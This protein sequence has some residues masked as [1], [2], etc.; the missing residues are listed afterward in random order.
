MQHLGNHY[1]LFTVTLSLFTSI[2]LPLLSVSAVKS[3]TRALVSL[4]SLAHSIQEMARLESSIL[5]RR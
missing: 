4:V 2:T 5:C 3:L 1:A